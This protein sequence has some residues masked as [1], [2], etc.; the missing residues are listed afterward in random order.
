MSIILTTTSS[1]GFQRPDESPLSGN[2]SLDSHGDPGLQ[3]VSHTCEAINTSGNPCGEL[4][5]FVLPNDQFSSATLAGSLAANSET[6]Y[7]GIRTTDGGSAMNAIPSYYLR[8]SVT[9]N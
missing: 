9:G 2:W 6:L 1:D 7:V 4:Y 5:T 8:V 3:V